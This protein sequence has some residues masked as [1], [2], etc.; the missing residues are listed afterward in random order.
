MKSFL[1]IGFLFTALIAFAFQS[2]GQWITRKAKD[3]VING[4][5]KYVSW[6]STVDGITAI[7]FTGVKVSGTVSAIVTL[8]T[9]VDS[10]S[11][12]AWV[13]YNRSGG[14]TADTITFT[15][16]DNTALFPIDVHYGNGYRIKIV[17]TGTQKFY[18][19]SA[20]LRRGRK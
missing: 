11:T 4:V 5:T 17:S 12:L 1:K 9:R 3:S 19:Y 15:D 7:Q 18:A 2:P 13:P 16:G 10:F 8:E 6:N 14:S 20:Y